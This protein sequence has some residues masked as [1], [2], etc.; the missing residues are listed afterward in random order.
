MKTRNGLLRT[1]ASLVVAGS[2]AAYLTGCGGGGGDSG[3]RPSPPPTDPLPPD[4]APAPA[5]PAPADLRPTA[6]NWRA[7]RA[8]RGAGALESA[9]PRFVG[10]LGVPQFQRTRTDQRERR[11]RGADHGTGRW[12]R[13][14][15]GGA[16]RRR[17]LLP[18]GPEPGGIR[19]SVRVRGRPAR[20]EPRN[21]CRGRHRRAS[22]RPRNSRRRL[23][24]EHRQ[25]RN[26]Q[27]FRRMLR[28]CQRG[29]EFRR[30]RSRYRVG[31][32]VDA[33]LRRELLRPRCQLPHHEHELRVHRRPH[34]WRDLGRNGSRRRCGTHHGCRAGERGA[35]RTRGRTGYQRGGRGD[36][37][38]RD[39]GRLA[40][41]RRQ[42]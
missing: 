6:I 1:T 19:C 13:D 39:R 17:R 32:G 22:R 7:H 21:E 14:H 33:N 31:S 29:A 10:D 42:R 38:K 37:R 23:Q 34:D 30:N 16:G 9:Q 41:P 11:L 3:V 18:S 26:L 28:R 12:Q 25:H 2:L 36:R 40:Q 4:P 35:H 15:R 20:R 8:R 5:A 24:R 27:A